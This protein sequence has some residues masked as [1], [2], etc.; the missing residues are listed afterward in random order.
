MI[1]SSSGDEEDKELLVRFMINGSSPKER[2]SI[3]RIIMIF[4]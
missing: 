4:P 2:R 3:K 1:A